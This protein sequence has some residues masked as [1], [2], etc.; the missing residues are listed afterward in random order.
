MRALE[1][2]FREEDAIVADNADGITVNV[3]EACKRH[4][5]IEF[6]NVGKEITLYLCSVGYTRTRH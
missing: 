6:K 5:E 3:G 2:G 4:K 1:S